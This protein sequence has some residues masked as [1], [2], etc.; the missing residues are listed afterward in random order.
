MYV[1]G[2]TWCHNMPHDATVY[3]EYDN[4]EDAK[5]AYD[6]SIRCE[7]NKFK[8]Y[9]YTRIDRFTCPDFRHGYKDE[10]TIFMTDFNYHIN[11]NE[12]NFCDVFLFYKEG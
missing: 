9:G 3:N 10:N 4:Y 6:E 1:V 8:Q 5:L 12:N 7:Q 11:R 2:K